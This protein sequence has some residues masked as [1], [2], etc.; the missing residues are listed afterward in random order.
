MATDPVEFNGLLC[1]RKPL[2]W[3]AFTADIRAKEVPEG[4]ALPAGE[5]SVFELR[6][7]P[8]GEFQEAVSSPLLSLH[9]LPSGGRLYTSSGQCAWEQPVT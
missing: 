4:F 8:G 3:A 6:L 2:S 7:R 9:G 1:P 5:P